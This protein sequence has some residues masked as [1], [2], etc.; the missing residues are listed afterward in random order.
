MRRPTDHAGCVRRL[1]G[2]LLGTVLA[3]MT[4]AVQAAEP[5]TVPA[6]PDAWVLSEGAVARFQRHYGRDALGLGEVT[7]SEINQVAFARG[8]EFENGALEVDVA[9]RSNMSFIG[10]VFRA[11]SDADYE[12]VYLR[13]ASSG[14]GDAIQYAPAYHREIGWQLY[15]DGQASVEFNQKSWNHLKVRFQGERLEVYVN[16]REQPSLVTRLRRPPAPGQVGVFSLYETYF[17][18][19]RYVAERNGESGVP[20]PASEPQPWRETL[21]GPVVRAPLMITR[22]QLSPVQLEAEARPETYPGAAALRAMSWLPATTDHDGLL[23]IV[24][25][26]A[27]IRGGRWQENSRDVVWARTTLRAERARVARLDL[28]YSDKVVLYLNGRP[29][30]AGNNT[31]LAQRGNSLGNLGL[32]SNGVYLPLRAGDNELLMAVIEESDGWGLIARL[33]DSDGV[34]VR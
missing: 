9:P 7:T 17:A 33:D 34:S 14:G 19:F 6:T 29:L 3:S 4:L 26:R 31:F 16:D 20:V 8:V 18:N 24:K 27:K 13:T 23:P 1:A 10:L 21:P 22:W 32:G 28:D 15:P 25:Y 12:V 30:F 11:R 5:H 2:R